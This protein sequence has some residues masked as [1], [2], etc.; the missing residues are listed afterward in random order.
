MLELN[1]VDKLKE[2]RYKLI[3]E[4]K[5]RVGDFNVNHNNK[6]ITWGSIY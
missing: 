6:T 3:N 5:S 1:Y 2:L 4:S